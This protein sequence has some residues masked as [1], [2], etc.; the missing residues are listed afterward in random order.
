MAELRPAGSGRASSICCATRS[1]AQQAGLN[2]GIGDATATS[3]RTA[4]AAWSWR[5]R[6]GRRTTPTSRARSTPGC[7][8]ST[9]ADRSRR[10]PDDA[11]GRRAAA[12]AARSSS[13]AAT[14]SRVETEAVVRRESILNTVGSL[15]LILPLLYLAFRSPWLV[16]VGS[17]PSALSL[18]VVLGVLGFT[19]ATLSAAAAGSAAMLFGL[20][21]DGVVLLYVAYVLARGRTDAG[22]DV[23]RR[24]PDR[25][26]SMLLGMW[27]TAATFYGLMF[28]DFPSL[29]QLGLLIGHSMVVC[30]ILTL[31]LVPALL[32]RRPS[33]RRSAR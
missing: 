29:Q 15:A 32:P 11:A 6:S 19:G 16:A 4:A 28:V 30:G 13:P 22:V 1:A 5:G 14:A 7:A 3:P 9:R 25:R 27:T 31:V 12:A 23:R 26:A 20:G 18:V 10:Q 21:V 8:R 2:I 24:S 33:R 17:L